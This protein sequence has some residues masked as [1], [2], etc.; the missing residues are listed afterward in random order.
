MKALVGLLKSRINFDKHLSY[1]ADKIYISV[2]QRSRF[3]NYTKKWVYPAFNVVQL[4][5]HWFDVC[6]YLRITAC[7]KVLQKFHSPISAQIPLV[8]FE[9]HSWFCP[10]K[11]ENMDISI[12]LIS[13]HILQIWMFCCDFTAQG[14]TWIF[15]NLRNV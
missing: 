15:L 2:Y 7:W 1:Q 9:T 4:K 13:N 14:I 3:E 11:T 8:C 5:F 6:Y 12:N 10:K